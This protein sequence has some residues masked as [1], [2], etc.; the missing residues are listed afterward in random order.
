MKQNNTARKITYILLSAMLMALALTFTGCNKEK[1]TYK[2]PQALEA[3]YDKGVDVIGKNMLV[4][5]NVTVEEPVGL[6]YMGDNNAGNGKIYVMLVD[7]D[8]NAIASTIAEDTEV[9]TIVV[10]YDAYDNNSKYIYCK[11][12]EDTAE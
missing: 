5:A 6:F 9:D 7:E 12:A 2:S 8:G 4:N 3:A 10:K 1:Q 11:L